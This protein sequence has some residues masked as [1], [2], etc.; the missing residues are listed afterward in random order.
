MEQ[1]SDNSSSYARKTRSTTEKD[2]A[3]ANEKPK[4]LTGSSSK[5]DRALDKLVTTESVKA[6][7]LATQKKINHQI[8]KTSRRYTASYQQ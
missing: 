7:L 5:S 8:K 2:R 3:L 6:N 4:T 1:D